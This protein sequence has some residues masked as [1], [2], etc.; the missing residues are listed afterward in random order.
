MDT[1]HVETLQ[2]RTAVQQEHDSLYRELVVLNGGQ[3]K[4]GETLAADVVVVGSGAGGGTTVARL[5]QHGLDVL[6][7]EEGP[8]RLPSDF[9]LL[10]RDA[11]RELYQDAGARRTK[12]GGITILQGR[13]V[14]GGT[15]V[16]W[17]AS[18]RLPQAIEAYWIEHCKLGDLGED[19]LAPWF[20]R[21][22]TELNVSPWEYPPN[23]NNQVLADGLRRLGWHV[24]VV[25]RNVRECA[26]LGYCGMGCVLNAKQSML[27]TG[28]P[29]ALKLGARLVVRMRIESIKI[30]N[31]SA[32]RLVGVALDSDGRPTGSR[33]SIVAEHVVLAGGSIGTPSILM[34]SGL[35][36]NLPT[37]GRNTFL[38]PTVA[39]VGLFERAVDGFEGAPQ[40]IYS[41]EFVENRGLMDDIGFK[42]E[43]APVHP[44]LY[45]TFTP[46][47][48]HTHAK[49]ADKFRHVHAM[50]ALLRD[51]FHPES[52]GGN[53]ELDGK[54]NPVLDYRVTEYLWSGVRQ[55]FH[56]MAKIQWAAGAVGVMPAHEEA[57]VY[58]SQSASAK[59]IDVLTL[60]SLSARL[61]S[62]HV[63]GGCA[64]GDSKQAGVV[65]GYGR[66]HGLKN[67]SVHDAS[68]FPTSLGTNPQLTIYA[69]AARNA[70]RL[71]Q[72]LTGDARRR[73]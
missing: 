54:G 38:H 27:V 70:E 13:C 20:D 26:N 67:V 3:L 1:Y 35:G 46:G 44:M 2:K 10:E 6:L 4:D 29:A 51:G 19:P 49:A 9:T 66:V 47:F 43:V 62:A 45:G 16:N 22:E 25:P 32:H 64:M 55:A 21:I 72:T 36:G 5:A 53:L 73:V 37:L 52:Q 31:G 63:M 14:G 59:A 65:D 8:L 18:F 34:R 15:T 69:I 42:L 39:S 48:G 71:A 58:T 41:D 60:R 30:R 12:D 24:G 23:R 33:I 17:T 11:Y 40:S 7:V 68:V 50:V 61:F 28:I 57:A 56:A